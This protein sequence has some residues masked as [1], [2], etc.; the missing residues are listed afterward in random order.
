MDSVSQTMS[1]RRPDIILFAAQIFMI[2]VV[3]VASIVNLSCGVGN[4]NLWTVLLTSCMG[5]VM[6]NPRLKAREDNKSVFGSFKR[7]NDG[8]GVLHDVVLQQHNR[9]GKH[10]SIV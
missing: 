10:N 8:P 6:P 9:L 2:V 7:T 5:I 3:T 4:Q 1:L